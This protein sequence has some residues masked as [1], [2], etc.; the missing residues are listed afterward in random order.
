M[1]TS[2]IV[3]IIMLTV[4]VWW[5]SPLYYITLY[6]ASSNR[7]IRPVNVYEEPF[8]RRTDKEPFFVNDQKGKRVKITPVAE[9]E[10]Q[11]RVAINRT[12]PNYFNVVELE[13][14]LT[15]DMALVWGKFAEDRIMKKMK[16]SHQWTYSGF[17]YTDPV[18]NQEPGL[19]YLSE[20]F[21]S[22]HL[23]AAN[24]NIDHALRQAGKGDR[25][26]VAGYLVNIKITGLPEI[27][28]SL[29]RTDNWTP[30]E[31][32]RGG[33]EFIY[34]TEFQNGDRVYK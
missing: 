29:V 16:F 18:L 2:R 27:K 34:V 4:L 22:N 30:G 33:S 10:I 7:A 9:Y 8:Q 20:H 25:I 5:W 26:R 24:K 32:N 31:G 13:N 6:P 28:T 1:K 3:G 15:N 14:L 23:V 12:Y 19:Q 11:A 21:S 17:R